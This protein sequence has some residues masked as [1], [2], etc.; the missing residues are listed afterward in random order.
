MSLF[1]CTICGEEFEWGSPHE[2]KPKE[3]IKELRQR[4]AMRMAEL[5]YDIYKDSSNVDKLATTPNK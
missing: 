2:H 1:K 4:D 5:I 3:S